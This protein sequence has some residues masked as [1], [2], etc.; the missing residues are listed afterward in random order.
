[1]QEIH[2]RLEAMEEVQ[3]QAP[4]TRD[5]IDAEREEVVG[6][7]VVE[8]TTGED[9]VRECLLRV[10]SILA[11]RDKIEVP[12][13]EGNLYVEE[14]LDWIRSMDKHFHYEEVDEEKKVK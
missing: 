11:G 8:E 2:A 6:K 7:N 3:R 9:V 1:M 5:I 12:M 13:Y 14:L 10:V 4:N